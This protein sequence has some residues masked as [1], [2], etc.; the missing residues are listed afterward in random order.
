[1]SKSNVIILSS[2]IAA[3]FLLVSVPVL[4]TQAYADTFTSDNPTVDGFFQDAFDGDCSTG[5]LTKFTA[6]GT[7][8][9]QNRNR[10]GYDCKVVFLE[11]DISSIP[12]NSIVTDVTFTFDVIE[13][14]HPKVDAPI[15]CVFKPI[16]TAQPS[17]ASDNAIFADLI[18]GNTVTDV[19]VTSSVCKTTGDN[20]VVDLG[21]QADSDVQS[22]LAN[23]AKGWF[24]FGIIPEIFPVA[25]VIPFQRVEIASEENASP[26][27]LPTLKI[28]F[29]VLTL[30]TDGDGIDDD[31]DNCIDV[32]NP[33]QE[34]AD[35]DGVGDACDPDRDGDGVDNAVDNCIDVHN[36]GQE[37]ADLD[38]VGDAC[39]PDRDGD[40]VDNA[41]DNCID[42]TNPDQDDSDDDGIGDV[43]DPDTQIMD[44]DTS[45]NL[46][47]GAGQTLVIKNGATMSGKI[48][49]DGGTL[50]LKDG[51]TV[52]GNIKATNSY[53]SIDSCTVTGHIRTN[54]GT[55]MISNSD[56]G[57]NLRVKSSL[58]KVTITENIVG[59][60]L[61]SFDNL[62]GNIALNVVTGNLNTKG[63]NIV[64][65]LQNTVTGNLR[66]SGATNGEVNANIVGKNLR[67]RDS[68]NVTVDNNTVGKNL[69][70]RDNTNIGVDYNSATQNIQVMKNDNIKIFNNHAGKNFNIQK[71][72][73]CIH[74][75]NSAD[76]KLKIKDCYEVTQ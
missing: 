58:D 21:T 13:I 44:S 63:T 29:T 4:V 74:V 15:D 66:V 24:A 68:N 14:T 9:V 38:G 12:V 23:A 71:N 42:V 30:D 25:T 76:N 41:V 59:G 43:C 37:D 69:R 7:L 48:S 55:V 53:V 10:G 40:G 60:H 57:K 6:G 61:R 62:S 56:I 70:I 16:E 19:Y 39:D 17:V 32:H 45:G 46:Q 2:I 8:S 49:V 65:V 5:L 47:V 27:P 31:V 73:E 51:C 50:N 20:K 35:L 28:T 72:I 22:T 18:F 36:P 64:D 3:T 11:Y 54:G 67:V 52:E 33:G 1:M 26:T 75:L 34:D